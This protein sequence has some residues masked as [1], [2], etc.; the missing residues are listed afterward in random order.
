MI[1]KLFKEHGHEIPKLILENLKQSYLNCLDFFQVACR[2]YSNYEFLK[3]DISLLGMYFFES[4]YKISKLFLKNQKQKQIYT[5]G[6]TPLSSMETIASICGIKKEDHIYDLGCGR[7]RV[8]FWLH[9]FYQCKVTGVDYIDTF[10]Q[11]ANKIRSK[12][13]L[14]NLQFINKNFLD[15]N[16]NDASV[17]YLYGTML[18]QNEIEALIKKFET[19]PPETKIITVS[20]PLN[21]YTDQNCYEIMN[22]FSV[23][24]PWGIADVYIQTRKK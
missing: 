2:Y 23:P 7:G 4:P 20:Y 17:I 24:F 18:T 15:L 5:Y 16:L 11:T 10:T 19:V 21:D 8:S 12:L 9:A 1:Y 6:E 22:H 3:A 14:K 13:Q